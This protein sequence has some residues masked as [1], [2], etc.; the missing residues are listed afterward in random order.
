MVGVLSTTFSDPWNN[1]NSTT[2]T[3]VDYG[4]SIKHLHG[5]Q[6]TESENHTLW[7]QR[8]KRG[9]FTIDLGGPFT[10]VRTGA[11]VVGNQNGA[12]GSLIVTDEGKP[13]AT[14]RHTTYSGPILPL[15][16]SELQI[17]PSPASSDDTLEAWGA[18]AIA[19]CSPSN[20]S[21][22]L[23]VTFGEFLRE[24]LPAVVGGTLMKWRGLSPQERRRAIGE[25]HLNVEFGLKPLA[26]DLAAVAVSILEHDRVLSQYVRDSG[27][28]VRRR[29]EF[30]VVESSTTEIV[31]NDCSPWFNPSSSSLYDGSPLNAGKVY[32]TEETRIRRWFSGAFT[33]YVPP[34]DGLRNSVAR[35]VIQ[36]RKLLGVSLTPDTLWNLSPWSW[37][38][39]WFTNTGDV[40][41]N[42][43][44]WAIDN[45]VLVYG[46][47]MEH[48]LRTYTYTFVGPR[49]YRG[50]SPPTIV[51]S[52][53][54]KRR[55]AANPYGFGVTWDGLSPRQLSIVGALGISRSK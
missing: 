21:A 43:T 16:P 13:W 52:H 17:P 9:L 48:S 1:K 27:K 19:R 2:S 51:T 4:Y 3:E 11:S 39:D 55:R 8:V 47:M 40:I 44:D 53:E 25:E 49:G 33:Y 29:Y 41:S 28:M 35:N 34:A 22:D 38:V 7:N 20:P 12:I 14:Y 42:L 31:R 26:N 46:Y 30:P 18:T 10:S 54:V 5:T 6:I 36:A 45:Q 23:A 15:P 50:T 32:R 37:A 24:G